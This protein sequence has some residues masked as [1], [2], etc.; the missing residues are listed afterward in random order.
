MEK[1]IIEFFI[2]F[3]VVTAFKKVLLPCMKNSF[4]AI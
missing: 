2:A 1:L 4:L 3:C